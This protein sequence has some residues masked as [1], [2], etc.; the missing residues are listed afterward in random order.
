MADFCTQC[1][2][3][4]LGEEGHSGDFVGLST[5]QETAAGRYLPVL[6]EGCG[7]TQV[8]HTGRCVSSDCIKQ[9]GKSPPKES[10]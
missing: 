5:A 6:C 7:Y 9:H 1:T 10:T 4:L 2:A 3:D 8:D